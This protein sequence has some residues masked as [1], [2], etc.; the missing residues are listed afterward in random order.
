[1]KLTVLR[2]YNPR[3]LAH[4]TDFECEDEHGKVRRVDLFVDSKFP[5]DLDAK[6]L[7]G[8]TI[9]VDDLYPF[10]ELA[11]N[12]RIAEESESFSS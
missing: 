1:M 4:P 9:I 8:K 10:L 7:I 11:A 2:P 12:P 6:G 5:A 3:G